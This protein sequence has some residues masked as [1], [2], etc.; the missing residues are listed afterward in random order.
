MGFIDFGAEVRETKNHTAAIFTAF[1]NLRLVFEL[2][3]VNFNI[4]K[5]MNGLECIPKTFE[6]KEG[7]QRFAIQQDQLGKVLADNK[8]LVNRFSKLEKQNAEILAEQIELKNENK[9]LI[10]KIEILTNQTMQLVKQNGDFGKL[11]DK[12]DWSRLIN[13]TE[14]VHTQTEKMET[15]DK[16]VNTI[17]TKTQ[18]GHSQTVSSGVDKETNTRII[19]FKDSESNTDVTGAMDQK[20]KIQN[21]SKEIQTVSSTGPKLYFSHFS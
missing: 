7:D 15:V 18:N 17:K 16:Q 13:P 14:S 12:I 10:D 6:R 11:F 19:N 3:K 5:L 8:I 4:T 2:M 21:T 9:N 1:T 20:E